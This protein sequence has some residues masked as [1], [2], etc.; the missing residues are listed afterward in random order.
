MPDALCRL[1]KVEERIE[2]LMVFMQRHC[3]E[4][5]NNKK[6]VLAAIQEVKD[7]Q[8][9]QVGFIRGV[10][11]TVSAIIGVIGLIFTYWVKP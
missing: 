3:D 5:A 9:N 7:Y 6:E 10:V 1:A 4:E 8:K 2:V 11:F